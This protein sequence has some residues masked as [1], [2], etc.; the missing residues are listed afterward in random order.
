M[1]HRNPDVEGASAGRPC[2]GVCAG[3]DYF[4]ASASATA[5]SQ[6]RNGLPAEW[7]RLQWQ[8]EVAKAAQW[9]RLVWIFLDTYRYTQMYEVAWE[10]N[11]GG[12]HGEKNQ[13]QTTQIMSGCDCWN[14]CVFSLRRNIVGDGAIVMMIITMKRQFMRHTN[15]LESLI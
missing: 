11:C 15:M 13:K 8:R 5:V 6:W 3:A 2:T 1:D 7:G 10:D 12:Y 14:R 4:H 9:H